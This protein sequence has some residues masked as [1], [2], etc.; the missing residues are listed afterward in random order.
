ML[1][2][3]LLVT[4][5]HTEEAV[6]RLLVVID[7]GFEVRYGRLGTPDLWPTSLLQGLVTDNEVVLIH[8]CPLLLG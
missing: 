6:L 1:E 8:R 5:L 7:R 3:I 4:P 2:T